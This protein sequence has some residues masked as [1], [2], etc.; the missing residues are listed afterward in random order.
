MPHQPLRGP[1]RS[2]AGAADYV[3]V[4]VR[5]RVIEAA[6]KLVQRNMDRS[7]GVPGHPLVVFAHVQNGSVCRNVVDSDGIEV[8]HGNPLLGRRFSRPAYRQPGG[9]RSA[10]GTLGCVHHAQ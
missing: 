10:R 7:L 5:I 6:G 1:E 4:L 2:P 3:E 9:L 8:A